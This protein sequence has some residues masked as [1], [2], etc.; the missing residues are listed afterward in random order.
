M[1]NL[2]TAQIAPRKQS[3]ELPWYGDVANT[4]LKGFYTAHTVVFIRSKECWIL[5]TDE[6]KL[7]ISQSE[8]TEAWLMIDSHLAKNESIYV[9][10]DRAGWAIG[11][12]EFELGWRSVVDEKKEVWSCRP[13]PPNVIEEPPET[14]PLKRKSEIPF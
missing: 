14:R 10:V 5:E 1:P 3:R 12:D 13:V 6:F 7:W 8:A 9:F 11:S 4:L 2:T